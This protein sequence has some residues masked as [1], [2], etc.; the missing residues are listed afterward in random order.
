MR[1]S[2][3]TSLAAINSQRQRA[4][5]TAYYIFEK[6]WKYPYQVDF[7]HFRA[8]SGSSNLPVVTG[9][10]NDLDR[11][12][13]DMIHTSTRIWDIVEHFFEGANLSIK[14]AVA[15]QIYQRILDHF[16][17]H[18]KA[19]RTDITYVAPDV[20][21]FRMMSE[22]ATAIRGYAVDHNPGIDEAPQNDSLAMLMARRPV[23]SMQTVA[24][25]KSNEPI[26]PKSV[27]KMDAIERYMETLNGY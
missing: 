10:T 17:A 13:A 15:A 19:M 7:V 14:P 22:F 5:D 9:S 2:P 26:A 18:L 6:D 4:R 20:E 25:D 11:I 3:V 12:A 1:P 21:D 23:F 24:E 8:K 16:D 27:R